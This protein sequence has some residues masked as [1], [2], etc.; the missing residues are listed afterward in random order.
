MAERLEYK[1]DV[2]QFWVATQSDTM[3]VLVAEHCTVNT[4][5]VLKTPHRTEDCDLKL[6]L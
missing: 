3:G 5:T 2:E 4:S 1:G 6:L